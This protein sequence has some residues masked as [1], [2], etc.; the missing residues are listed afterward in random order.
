M[1]SHGRA[2]RG[3][4]AIV[5][6][7]TALLAAPPALAITAEVVWNDDK[8]DFVLVKNEDGHAVVL[9]ASPISLQPGDVLDG[10]LDQ[11]GFFRKIA[12][13][14]TG[15]TTMMRTMKYGVRRK[16]AVEIMQDW[17]SRC[18]PPER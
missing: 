16:V 9:K 12:K 11:V 10:Q 2:T 6:A 7:A 17:S 5:T 14:G 18:D 1:L 15:E 8:C 3:L 4:C 13:A